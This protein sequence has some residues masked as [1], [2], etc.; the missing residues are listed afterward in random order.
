MRRACWKTLSGTLVFWEIC[1]GSY[2]IVKSLVI[3][4]MV[5]LQNT[6]RPAEPRIRA[7]L[8]GGSVWMA[9][10]A[11]LLLI[12]SAPWLNSGLC[13]KMGDGWLVMF[14]LVLEMVLNIQY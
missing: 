9:D 7:T 4:V 13:G 5:S 8:L 14:F 2:R 1:L 3:L 6:S 11:E 10:G 12:G